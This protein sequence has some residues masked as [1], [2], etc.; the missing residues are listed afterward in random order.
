MVSKSKHLVP[1]ELVVGLIGAMSPWRNK[2]TRNSEQVWGFAE[3]Q[4]GGGIVNVQ[5]LEELDALMTEF[6]FL[7]ISDTEIYP[8]VDLDGVLQRATQAIQAA[9][10]RAGGLPH[11]GNSPSQAACAPGEDSLQCLRWRETQG[12]PQEQ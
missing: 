10:A 8:V 7:P 5:S 12:N 1:P 3:F 11:L 4:G 6:P 2:Y 9:A